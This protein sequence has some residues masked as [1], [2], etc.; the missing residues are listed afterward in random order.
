MTLLLQLRCKIIPFPPSL[1][2]PNRVRSISGDSRYTDKH[3]CANVPCSAKTWPDGVPTEP[4]RRGNSY[5]KEAPACSGSIDEAN[6]GKGEAREGHAQ[7]RGRTTR[8]NSSE[9]S[10]SVDRMVDVTL[11]DLISCTATKPVAF[12]HENRRYHGDGG[13]RWR[14]FST[15]NKSR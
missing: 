5:P 4:S 9:G 14:I 10:R 2:S 1:P 11:N 6:R 8:G 13:N 3:L 12:S 15:G 7:M